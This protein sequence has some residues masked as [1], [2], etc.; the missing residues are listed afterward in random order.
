MHRI[1]ALALSL[2][3]VA[4]AAVEAQGAFAALSGGATFGDLSGGVVNS[5]SRWGGT[6]GIA[7]GYRNFSHLI[8]EL[9][10]NWVQ[11]GGD[12][13]RIDYIEIPLLFGGVAQ[14]ANG[15]GARLYTGIGIAFPISCKSDVA[16]LAC[17]AKKGT[18]WAWPIG[19]QIG[20]WLGPNRFVALDARYSIGLSD[21]FNVSL[22]TN[23]SWQ[24]R[25]FVGFPIGQ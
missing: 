23:R 2:V 10:G 9:E 13:T 25:A 16:S 20:R 7:L 14:A 3:L 21:A 4:A 19:L 5:D 8:T 6:A 24:F 15:L 17:D 18:E 1:G 11:K 12:G 22:A